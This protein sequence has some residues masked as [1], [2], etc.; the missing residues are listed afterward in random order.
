[1]C[2]HTL[3]TAESEELEDSPA[4]LTCKPEV[5]RERE[6]ER[7]RERAVTDGSLQK[8]FESEGNELPD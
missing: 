4:A 2:A 8:T 6:R 3:G 5:Q 7:A 1:M